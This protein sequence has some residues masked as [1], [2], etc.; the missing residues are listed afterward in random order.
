MGGII[1]FSNTVQCRREIFER[2]ERSSEARINQGQYDAAE[3]RNYEELELQIF[4]HLSDLVVRIGFERDTP[5]MAKVIRQ[6]ECLRVNVSLKKF[7]EPGRRRI[8]RGLQV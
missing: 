2:F 7:V 4:P 8:D 3:A 1:A 6:R 5:E